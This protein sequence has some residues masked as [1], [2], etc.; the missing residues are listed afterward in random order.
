[1]ARTGQQ[2]RVRTAKAMSQSQGA[3]IRTATQKKSGLGDRL[4]YMFDNSMTRGT[5][6]L[7]AW[8]TV[9]TL[10]MTLF[11]AVVTTILRLRDSGPTG[12]GFLH[13]V[14][15]TLLHA[16]DPGYIGGDVG[17]WGFLL[18]ML[19][20]TVGGLFIVSALIGVIANGID[21]KLSDLRRGRS[22]V[23][24]QEHTVILGLS[25]IHISE[26]TRPY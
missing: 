10:A 26:P 5:P 9:A 7:I 4:R 18:T 24:E 6:A 15:Y 11:F 20:L 1:M 2:L 23:L 13:E 3:G 12:D 14:F 16:L 17:G 19:L 22:I 8:L 21:T 25:L